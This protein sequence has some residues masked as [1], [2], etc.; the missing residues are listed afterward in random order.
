MAV[1]H[2]RRRGKQSTKLVV[3]LSFVSLFLQAKQ[4]IVEETR[5]IKKQKLLMLFK[6]TNYAKNVEENALFPDE[7]SIF[8][9]RKEWKILLKYWIILVYLFNKKKLFC[10]W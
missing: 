6:M 5:I 2:K 7:M 4:K 10:R 3:G 1:K 9:V 8:W